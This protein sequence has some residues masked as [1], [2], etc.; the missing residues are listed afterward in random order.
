MQALDEVVD[1]V[2]IGAGFCGLATGAALRAR[3]IDRF[4]I[5]EQGGDVGDFWSRTY[6]R[7]HLHSAWHDLPHDGG[8]NARYP[9]YKSRD[10]VVDYCQR[11]AAHYDLYRHLLPRHRV[12]HVRH[13]DPPAD[14]GVEW[15]VETA[16]RCFAARYLVVA[17]AINRVPVRPHVAAE[18]RFGGRVLH[19]A[20]YR[21]AAPFKGQR[22]LIVGS[23]NSGAEIGLDLVEGGAA[24]V[25]LWVRAPRHFIPLRYMSLLFRFFRAIGFASPAQLDKM[26][27]LTVGTAEFAKTIAV[28][29]ALPKRFSVDLSRYG[30]RRPLDGPMTETF[31]RGRIAVFDQGAIPLI[32]SGQ[33]RIIDGNVRPI[34]SFSRNG[35]RFAGGAEAFDAVIF[36]AG[37][38][39]QLEQFLDDHAAMLGRVRWHSLAPLTDGRSRSRVYPSAFFP[40]F[41]P[42]VNGGLSLGRWGWEAGERIAAE[43]G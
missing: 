10:D 43:R 15:R 38:A 23:G 16:S 31:T 34:E 26:H 32:R 25:H 9:M 39:P 41:D 14:G 3:G 5:L 17:T 20:D 33:I 28:R 2:I 18:E 13:L 30:I 24:S 27:R 21:N 37:Y 8:L 6:D 11:Y 4:V 19:S 7:L 36:A 40:G 12:E 42:S 1:V 29:D 22:V 35:V